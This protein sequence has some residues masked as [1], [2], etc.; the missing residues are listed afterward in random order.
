[1]VTYM[2][3]VI[4][5]NQ[6]KQPI[7]ATAEVIELNSKTLVAKAYSDPK[8][9]EFLIS[10]PDKGSYAVNVSKSGY[11][12]YSENIVLEDTNFSITPFIQ[13]IPLKTIKAGATAVLNNIFFE[14]NAYLLKKE[15]FVELDKLVKM[16]KEQ[17]RI[18]I[19][20]S[21][22]TDNTGSETYNLTLSEKRAKAVYDYLVENNIDPSRLTYVGYGYKKP[23][24]SN[25]TE[26]GR[27][28][29]RR[30]EIKIISE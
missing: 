9:G 26:D 1:M 3:G 18:H 17:S 5:D 11:L 14:T 7:E 23:I 27:K 8:T 10:L 22:H 2:K 28:M 15:S 24:A 25:D 4:F 30:T 12:F 13:N 20:I 29:N 16:L 19:E 6:T 21:G